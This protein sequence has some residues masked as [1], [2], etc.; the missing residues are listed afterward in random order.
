[1]KT[2]E[3][4]RNHPGS[5]CLVCRADIV[6]GTK[7]KLYSCHFCKKEFESNAVCE[8][9]HFICNECHSL[10]QPDFMQ[11]LLHSTEDDPIKLFWEI[12]KLDH[13]HM[14]GPEH[15]SI[16]PCIMLT[17]YK[18][19]GGVLELET[20]L[21]IAAARAKEVPGGICGL[22]GT[23]GA[24][25]GAGI[26]ASVV[27]G[28]TPLNAESWGIPQELSARCLKRIA[29]TGGPRCCKRTSQTA[30]ETAVQFTKEYLGVELPVSKS[31]CIY[32]D[33][34][35]ECR[36]DSCPYYGEPDGEISIQSL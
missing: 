2:G 18:N 12:V 11:L 6:Y 26:Y 17:A 1:M 14:H 5:G 3:H 35:K 21:E 4:N 10:S 9:G 7:S 16:V 34:N 27:T 20:A 22:W 15:H 31:S 24:A 28:S 30:I 36:H 19:S 33:R 8:N 29:K 23:C 13:V 25:V 32:S